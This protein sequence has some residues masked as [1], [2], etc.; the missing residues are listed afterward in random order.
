MS[1][2]QKITPCLWFENQALEAAQ[3]YT[4]LFANSEILNV[5]KS[6][7]D[8]PGG[9]AGAV[10]MVAFTIA[11]QNYQAL[12]GGPYATFNDAISLSVSC[13]DQAEV[14]RLW[15]ALTA[16][17]GKPVQC[18]WLKDKY[19]LSWQIVPKRLMELMSGSDAE[20]NKRVMQAMMK[21][22]KFDIVQLEAAAAV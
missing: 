20:R 6:A 11:G 2:A 21:M 1:N 4:S 22:I 13:D 9:K 16:D 18:G 14:D 10:L 8:Y 12:N 19:G 15:A 3:F 17:G 7:L 5:Q